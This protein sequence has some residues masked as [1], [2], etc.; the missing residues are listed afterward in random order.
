MKALILVDIQNEWA[1]N[2][3]SYFVDVDW[4]KYLQKINDLINKARENEWKIIFTMHIE[5]DSVEFSEES[6]NVKL[7]NGLNVKDGDVIVTKHKISPFYRT[8]L[9]A[10]LNGVDEIF[11]AG[12]LT[13]LCVRSLVSDAYDREYKI[14][15]VKNCCLAMDEETNEWTLKDLKVTRPEINIIDNIQ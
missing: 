13:N 3:S 10:E 5:L 14:T 8:T 9:E 2:K 6:E 15:I 11:T 12:I 1:D 7:L 4:K